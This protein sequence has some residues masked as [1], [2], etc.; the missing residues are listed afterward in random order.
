METLVGITSLSVKV[1][2]LLFSCVTRA[3]PRGQERYNTQVFK[4][5]FTL[6]ELLSRPNYHHVIA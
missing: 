2:C 6:T 5:R 4:T 3:P 1:E